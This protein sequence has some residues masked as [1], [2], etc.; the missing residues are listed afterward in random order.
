[1]HFSRKGKI[2]KEAMR[3]YYELFFWGRE[4]GNQNNKT[5]ALNMNVLRWNLV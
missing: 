3:F 5:V 1:M 2:N 4:Q